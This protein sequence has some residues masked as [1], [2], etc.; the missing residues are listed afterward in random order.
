MG[1]QSLD[2]ELLRFFGEEVEKRTDGLIK[3]EYFYSGAVTKPGEELDAVR[4]GLLDYS[5]V[6]ALYFPVE[7]YLNNIC[8]ALAFTPSDVAV[9]G[10]IYADLYDEVPAF[11]EEWE[12]HGCKHLS[13]VWLDSYVLLSTTP[14]TKVDD[15]KGKKIAISGVYAPRLVEAT[16]ATALPTTVPERGMALQTG[17]LDGSIIGLEVTHSAK[18][19]DFAKHCTW[20][21]FGAWIGGG[22][23]INLE[24]FNSW[25]KDI[26]EIV[27]QVGKEAEEQRIKIMVNTF[28]PKAQADMEA[29]GVTFY[30]FPWEE[31]VKWGNMMPDTVNEWIAEGESK[32]LPARKAM[33]TF[34][35][36]CEEQGHEFPREWA[37]K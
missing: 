21:D 29:T 17:M 32:G 7:L 23:I 25:P 1:P 30:D 4:T 20:I 26:Q 10:E 34:L 36:L 9:A 15:L 19:Y 28:F 5:L 2:G 16:G 31:K 3:C 18:Y 37:V 27:A 35:A 12:K 33:E 13:I 14:I 8:Y 11:R 24:L 6:P 22:D